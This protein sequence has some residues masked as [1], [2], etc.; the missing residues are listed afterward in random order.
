MHTPIFRHL[1]LCGAALSVTG[2]ASLNLGFLGGPRSHGAERDAKDAVASLKRGQQAIT[3]AENAVA[4]APR[5]AGLRYLLGR[6]Y[7]AGGRLASAGSA[8]ADALELN[9]QDT[10]SGLQL[11]L[12]RAGQGRHEEAR[13]IIDKH[14]AQMEVSDYGLALTLTGDPAAGVR[15]L[16]DAAR[17]VD[18][19]TLRQNLAFSYAAA[20]QWQEAKMTAARDLGPT[21]AV[22]RIAEWA[23]YAGAAPS[24]RVLAFLKLS[25]VE[26]AGQPARLALGT[27]SAA[28]ALAE[29]VPPK[30]TAP[31]DASV[32]AP[33]L[34]ETAP[35]PTP[36]AIA[37]VPA[38][39]VALSIDLAPQPPVVT[40]KAAVREA[41]SFGYAS[42]AL[43][44]GFLVQL[45][46]FD[47]AANAKSGW[48]RLAKRHALS[49][50]RP[51]EAT[52]SVRGNRYVRL[53]I[54]SFPSFAEA[55][56]TCRAIRARGGACFV[57]TPS[58]DRLASW[59]GFAVATR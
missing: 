44:R 16:E 38:E 56:S 22:R 37:P 26:D 42:G 14:A 55:S 24:E 8:F 36:A 9:P 25:P 1:L 49:A 2:C 6:A 4:A 15:V 30:L 47:S 32:D 23:S 59:A 21:E 43:D 17:T 27:A 54:G 50:H 11:A 28:A 31:V 13:A 20:G 52:V 12:V 53:S 18:D 29:L 34:A 10:R 19:V 46:A 40:P 41:P 48:Q 35:V 3:Q 57:R 7:F 51:A 39:K 33:V 58:G 5:D 45:G